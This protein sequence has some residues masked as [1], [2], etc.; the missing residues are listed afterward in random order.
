MTIERLSTPF[1]HQLQTS[2]NYNLETIF[3]RRE[4][5]TLHRDDYNLIDIT[6]NNQADQY[7]VRNLLHP[8]FKKFPT[9]RVLEDLALVG[10]RLWLKVTTI[11]LK[12][13]QLYV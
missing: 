3:R 9:G 2:D 13:N 1:Y 12:H 8:S 5:Q 4:E 7:F 10:A 6:D 11:H